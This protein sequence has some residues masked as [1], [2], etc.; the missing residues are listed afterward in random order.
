MAIVVVAT[1]LV[2]TIQVPSA[3][4]ASVRAQQWSLDQ[5]AVEIVHPDADGSGV[6]VAVLDTAIATGHSDLVGRFV[7]GF[8]F[9]ERRPYL[10]DASTAI[11]SV[12]HGT[13][14][15]GI[16]AADADGD[17]ITGVAP[18]VVIMPVRVVADDGTGDTSQLAEGIT[19]AVDNGADVINVSIRSTTDS[20]SVRTAVQHAVDNGVIIVASAGRGPDTGPF[21]PAALDGVIAVGAVDENRI[22]HSTSPATPAVELVAPGANTITTSGV[23]PDGYLPGWGTSFAAPHVTGTVAI[24]REIAPE[25][26]LGEIREA[27]Q[28]TAIDLGPI[29]RDDQYGYG[30]LDA[31]GALMWIDRREP[32]PPTSLTVVAGP[33]SI[34]IGWAP[35]TSFDVL[36]YEVVIGAEVVAVVDASNSAVQ[37]QRP[38]EQVVDVT[39]RSV[40][41]SSR[42]T[43]SV[44]TTVDLGQAEP[45]PNQTDIAVVVSSGRV[46]S[47]GRP[48]PFQTTASPVV[49]ASG[50]SNGAY[51]LT[52]ATG[53]I[54]ARGGAAFFGDAS[55][56]ALQAPIVDIAALADGTGYWLLGADG[57]VYAFGAAGFFG[58]VA[59]LDLAAPATAIVA[60]PG[61]LGYWIVA[62]DGGVFALGEAKF[63]GTAS[64]FVLAEPIVDL[65]ATE[66][67]YWLLGR[68]GGV[69]SFGTLFLGSLVGSGQRVAEMVASADGG[70]Y[71]IVG[72]NGRLSSFGSAD[73][74]QAATLS[75]GEVVVGVLRLG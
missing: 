40:D 24:M 36:G 22:A 28:S 68:D 42:R 6:V 60:S 1:V 72:L 52:D 26:T 51:W 57:G 12:N 46:V 23:D 74:D 49:A 61:K 17:G 44:L 67:G 29:G 75:V 66:A 50:T 39:V 59:H 5:L 69:F 32:E 11:A 63:V 53:T 19:W 7:D 31:V 58:S 55:G 70:G 64:G 27:L 48:I 14:V 62:Q 47:F 8:D 33:E 4:A 20:R 21:Y 45:R 37:V 13:M 2:P 16:I 25:A 3:G 30:M 15:A 41:A 73:L 18:G 56:I 38:D 34:T 54:S 9:V 71:T 10:A 65:A 43:P 35:S